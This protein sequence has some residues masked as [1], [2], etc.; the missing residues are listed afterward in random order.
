M[1][2]GPRLGPTD[3]ERRHLAFL[4]VRLLGPSTSDAAR[5]LEMAAEKVEGFNG[6]VEEASPTSVIAAFGLDPVDNPA[7]H[8]ALAALAIRNAATP[9][10]QDGA[11]MADTVLGIHCADHIVGRREGTVH[12]GADGKAATWSALE[13]LV[14]GC[15]PRTVVSEAVVPFLT[16]RFALERRREGERDVWVILGREELAVARS[17]TRFVGRKF[18][19]EALQRAA[20]RAEGGHGEIVSIVGEAGVGKSRLVH[21]AVHRLPGWLVLTSAGAPYA[22]NTSYF[23]LVEVLKAFCHVDDAATAAETRHR[24]PSSR[25]D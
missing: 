16:R 5:T 3:W 6:R 15:S 11:A 9:T 10:R 12:I 21:E 24:T 7:S 22:T 20:T 18:E 2:H 14:T 19:L 13:A 23:P 8:A 25:S 4:H 17:A 1:A